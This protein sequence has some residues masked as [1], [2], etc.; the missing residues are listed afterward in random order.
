MNAASLFGVLSAQPARMFVSASLQR[1]LQAG[2]RLWRASVVPPRDAES[3]V[4][5]VRALADHYRRIDPGFAADL[6]AA[7]DRHELEHDG[8]R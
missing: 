3:D 2:R 4:L 1:G 8:G 7:A 5:A 6:Y